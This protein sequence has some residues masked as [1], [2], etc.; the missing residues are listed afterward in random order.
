MTD[1]GSPVNDPDPEYRP[2][3][4]PWRWSIAAAVG[5]VLLLLAAISLNLFLDA[6]LVISPETTWITEPRTPDGKW[7]D[8]VA[9]LEQR[10]YPPE[11]QT[12][13]NGARLIIRALGPGV[14]QSPA[15]VVQVYEKLGLTPTKPTLTYEEPWACAERYVKEQAALGALPDGKSAS[16]WSRELQE[17]YERPWTLDDLPMMETWLTENGPALDLIA[18]A[19]QR[20]VL[21]F[22]YA[23]ER[24]TDSLYLIDLVNVQLLRGFVRG[25][26]ARAQYRVGTGDIDAAIDDVVAAARL[27]R[28]LQLDGFYIELLVGIALESMAHAVGVAAALDHP[29]SAEQLQRLIDELNQLPAR[30]EFDRLIENERYG[31]IDWIQTLAK[32]DRSGLEDES[33]GLK[34]LHDLGLPINQIGFDWTVVM[35]RANSNYEDLLKGRP[36]PA[37]PPH[38]KFLF[39][40][41][42]SVLLADELV[43]YLFPATSQIREAMHKVECTEHLLRISL[44][45]LLYERQHGTLPPAYTVDAAG[46]RLHS[47]R[48]LLLPFLGEEELYAR[49]RLDEPW[50][51]RHNAA[52]HAAADHLYQC[53]SHRLKPGETRYAVVEGP[54]APFDGPSA[55]KLGD[56]GPDSADML[57]V[58]ERTIAA[59][60]MDPRHEVPLANAQRGINV[61]GMT[62][63]GLGSVHPGGMQTGLRSGGVEFLSENFDLRWLGAR[64]E[65]KAQP[66]DTVEYWDDDWVDP[67]SA[68]SPGEWGPSGP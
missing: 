4:H 15:A 29:P 8:Y 44:A 48:V 56:F 14:D 5:V 62:D 20:P 11:M 28:L 1:S 39:R 36:P 3:A 66:V 64:L 22:P 63:V 16:D 50:D 21:C 68:P 32:G 2:P 13:D 7:V 40:G 9:A 53:P 31:F 47:W 24:D 46:N 57:L 55:R 27:G 18:E 54:G 38:W 45:M 23:R 41:P 33:W 61:R 37:S 49:I 10:R 34:Q 51:S 17:R 52:L 25:L 35:R 42:R 30:M 43:N 12:D 59:N 6:P 60:W 19:V 58:V 65:G 26:S 67:D